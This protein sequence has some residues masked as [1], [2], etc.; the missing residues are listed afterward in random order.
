M[1]LLNRSGPKSAGGEHLLLML[2]VPRTNDK[3]EL[4]AE[5]MLAALHGTLRSK[6][7]IRTSGTLQEHISLEVVAMGQRIRFYIWTPKHL[8]AFVEGQVYAQYPTV[9]I[10]EQDEDYTA[11]RLHQT[12]IHSAELTLTNNETLPIKTFPSFEVDPLAAITATLAK[13]DKEDEEMWI[14]IITRPISDDWHKRGQKMAQKIR[15]GGGL[16]GSGGSVV[17]YTAQMFGAL[18]KPPEAGLESGGPGELSER[19]KSRISAIEEK[20][21]KL[22]YQVKIRLLYTGHDQH[23]AR[24]RMQALVG[25]FKQFNTTNLNGFEVTRVSFD[26]DKQTQFQTRHFID[27]GFILNIE[28]LA[29]LFHL[30]HTTVETPN[31]VW[32]TTKTAEPPPN[33]PI[34]THGSE[35]D[36]SLFA[37]TNFRGDNTVFGMRREDRGRHTYILGQTGTGKSGALELLTLSDIYYDQGFAVIDPHGDYA[38]HILSFIP[39]RRI[40]DVVYFNPAD[41]DY[42][43]GFNPLEINDPALKGHISSELVGVLKRLF[44]ESWGPRLEYILRYTLLALLDYPNSTMLDVTRM[45]TDR[46]FRDGVISYIDDPVVKNFWVTEFASWNDKF[47][48]EAVA[49]VLNKV[50]AF[51]ANPMVRNIIGQPKSTFNLRQIMDHGKI[52]IVNLSRGLMGEDNAGILGAMMVT[53]IQLAAMTRASLPEEQRRAFY[54]Y[55]DEF[56]N[57][58]TDSFAVILSEARKYN[59]NLTVANQYISQMSEAVRDAVFG[60]VGTI[61]VFRVSPDDAPFLVKYFEPQFEA[62]DLI[63]QHARYFV[64]TMII[65]GEKA[66]PFSAKTLNLPVPAVDSSA[67]IIELSRQRYAQEKPVVEDLVRRAAGLAIDRPSFQPP[68]VNA[69]PLR[70]QAQAQLNRADQN[71]SAKQ[72]SQQPKDIGKIAAANNSTQTAKPQQQS[73]SSSRRRRRSRSHSGGSSTSV[74]K[75]RT[76]QAE[77]KERLTADSQEM[78]IRLR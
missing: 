75:T 44:A 22:G 42:P 5:Q 33:I 17:S 76:Q 49:P 18:T 41:T 36:I 24:L 2:E 43:I 25:A 47:A 10:Y 8:Q 71:M 30:P 57:F 77:S 48:S 28:E 53:K 70:P 9:Q 6:K 56:Q 15:R 32:A 67:Q 63:A 26:R 37:V 19:D 13:L 12:V 40:D 64:T 51:T 31:I 60:N 1:G 68:A 29:S 69:R 11:R 35:R 55:V 74:P 23:T 54:L 45:L 73:Q 62:G 4:A 38:Q 58:A 59:L 27:S 78:V 20:G 50:G 52:L 3:K 21:T 16:L 66:P 39:P 14:Q 72:R 61:I 65:N 46:K 7:E 34:Q